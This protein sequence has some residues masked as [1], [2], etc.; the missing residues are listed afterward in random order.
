MIRYVCLF[1][2]VNI[3]GGNKLPMASLRSA[4]DK[5][6]FN[7]VTT[8]IQNGN[9]VFSSKLEAFECEE[10]IVNI[11][12]SDFNLDVPVVVKEQ[13][14]FNKVLKANP[15]KTRT[16][17]NPKFMSFGFLNEAP[18]QERVNSISVFSTETETFE[19]IDDVIYF[20][21]GVEL[22]TTKMTNAFFEKEL[23]VVSTMRN[24]NT[25][26]KLTKL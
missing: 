19:I 20:Y 21:C 8:Y 5:T 10:I 3:S 18:S 15:F 13:S 22:G 7:S 4:L 23:D 24:Y 1:R 14:F 2:G 12:N 25:T 6:S 11:L 16:I 26:L 17:E 9:L